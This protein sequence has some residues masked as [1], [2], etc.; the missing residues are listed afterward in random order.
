MFQC[1]RNYEPGNSTRYDLMIATDDRGDHVFTW[2]NAPGGGRSMRIYSGGGALDGGYLAEKMGLRE[3]Q[4]EAD[5]RALLGWLS[6]Q[7]V[8][9]EEG[10]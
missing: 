8:N 5:I 4:R 7:G 10:Y 9:V 2:I 3:D 1:D 6:D